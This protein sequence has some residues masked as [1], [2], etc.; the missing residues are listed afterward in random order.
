[1][2]KMSSIEFQERERRVEQQVQLNRYEAAVEKVGD[3]V[4]QSTKKRHAE[5]PQRDGTA[6]QTATSEE[7][8]RPP[9]WDLGKMHHPITLYMLSHSTLKG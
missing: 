8:Q 1:M 5:S 9:L 7:R 4:G 2:R 3:I 6:A